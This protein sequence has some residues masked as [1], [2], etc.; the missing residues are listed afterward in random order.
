MPLPMY[1][2]RHAALRLPPARKRQKSY[3][4]E[5]T[6]MQKILDGLPQIHS[7]A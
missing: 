7:Q 2:L 4:Q 5:L 1:R 6:A 3:A